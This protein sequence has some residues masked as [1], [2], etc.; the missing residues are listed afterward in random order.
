[1]VSDKYLKPF[2]N[3]KQS[4]N[5]SS[6]TPSEQINNDIRKQN[7]QHN[8]IINLT[9]GISTIIDQGGGSLYKFIVNP[10]TNRKVSIYGRTGKKVLEYYLSI[11]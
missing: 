8:N 4:I 5:T 9:E 3:P 6:D 7:A 1:M 10:V 2:S 11:L